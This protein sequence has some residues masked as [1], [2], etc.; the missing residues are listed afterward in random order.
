MTAGCNDMIKI[1][2]MIDALFNMNKYMHL[3][4]DDGSR[5]SDTAGPGNIHRVS[6]RCD[7]AK[8]RT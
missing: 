8:M 5:A 3:S 1:L 7:E 6:V 4:L 2:R